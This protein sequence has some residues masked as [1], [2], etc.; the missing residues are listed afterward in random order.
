MTSVLRS[1]FP[2]ASFVAQDVPRLA[3][4][5]LYPEEQAHIRGAVESRRAEFATTRLAARRGLAE[6]GIAP[7]PLVPAADR[8]PMWPDGVVGSIAHTRDYCAVV[9]GR[10]PPLRSIGLDAEC[11]RE[12][13]DGVVDLILT[14][15]ERTWLRSHDRASSRSAVEDALLFFSAKEAFYKCQYPVTQRLLGFHDVE[16]DL[17]PQGGRFAVAVKK[18][19]FPRVVAR[20]EGRFAIEGGR[21]LC[22]VELLA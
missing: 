13:E 20:L 17:P 18:P 15:R 14:Q 12:L 11:V 6:M 1:L 10:R 5:G 21:V 19:D 7:V 16:L 3:D 8:A 4:D 2:H 22:G 9:L